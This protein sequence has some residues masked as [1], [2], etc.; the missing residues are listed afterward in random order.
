MGIAS[1]LSSEELA[2]LDIMIQLGFSTLQM[3]RRITHSR[4]CVRNYVLDTMAHGSAKP[5]GRPRILNDRNE[6]S[7]GTDAENAS[8]KLFPQVLNEIEVG[9]LAGRLHYDHTV[10]GKPILKKKDTDGLRHF[11]RFD[12]VGR[13]FRVIILLKRVTNPWGGMS[14]REHYILQD[15]FV[16][17]AIH[18]ASDAVKRS[19]PMAAEAGPYHHV[20]ANMFYSL[21]LVF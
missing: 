7:V 8:L 16:H 15:L 3:S 4:C 14:K 20:A 1:T 13:V 2:Q 6:R 5:T 11:I 10:G 17:K 18:V 21:S 12:V 19:D 9:A